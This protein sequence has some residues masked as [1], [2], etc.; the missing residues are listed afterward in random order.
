MN[1]DGSFRPVSR[2]LSR[3]FSDGLRTHRSA[4]H[5]DDHVATYDIQLGQRSRAP[6][7][8]LTGVQGQ[9]TCLRSYAP[10]RCVLRLWAVVTAALSAT[11]PDHRSMD[12]TS[13]LNSTW[14]TLHPTVSVRISRRATG[15]DNRALPVTMGAS[16]APPPG[17]ELPVRR[18]RRAGS[19]TRDTGSWR[20][21]APPDAI[22]R[23]AYE[24]I[25]AAGH[26]AHVT[27]S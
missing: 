10:K 13:K 2:Q 12:G 1:V 22:S 20:W 5:F 4:T 11:G 23:R 6:P 14:E 18:W 15:R 17:N 3:S 16:P 25:A 27:T 21:S 19:I 9:A 24:Y 7:R 26:G 8:M